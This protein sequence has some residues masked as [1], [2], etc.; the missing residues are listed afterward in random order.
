M[1]NLSFL[2]TWFLLITGILNAQNNLALLY[3]SSGMEY[4]K[5]SAVDA[6]TN[7]INGSL[8]Q[9]TI[10]VNPNGTTNH[11]APCAPTEIALTQIPH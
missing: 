10:N 6:D 11:T 2:V 7:Y 3:S 9:D 5:A 8:F 4:G 1:K